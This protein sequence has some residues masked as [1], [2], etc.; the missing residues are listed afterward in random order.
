MK[1]TRRLSNK[2]VPRNCKSSLNDT[3]ANDVKPNDV[4][5]S[6]AA[7]ETKSFSVAENNKS[8]C[9]KQQIETMEAAEQNIENICRPVKSKR[10]KQ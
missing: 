2:N 3:N 9:W 4:K 8:E 6:S 1:I 10:H 7:G 5:R